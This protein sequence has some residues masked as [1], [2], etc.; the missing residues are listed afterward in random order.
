MAAQ[1]HCSGW[2][3]YEYNTFHSFYC[4]LFFSVTGIPTGNLKVQ[5]VVTGGP[6]E[7]AG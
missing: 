3:Y 1:P 2:S 7:Q 5:E 4:L 6:A